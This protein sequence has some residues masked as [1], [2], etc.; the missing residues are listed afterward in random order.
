MP[1]TK[2]FDGDD[3]RDIASAAIWSQGH[4]LDTDLHE[5]NFQDLTRH[6][7][8]VLA[9][10]LELLAD[11]K[12]RTTS[13]SIA[14]TVGGA[15]TIIGTVAM[16]AFP[17]AGLLM[18]AGTATTVGTDITSFV[19]DRGD[20]QK[21]AEALKR[22]EDAELL[23][24]NTLEADVRRLQDLGVNATAIAASAAQLLTSLRGFNVATTHLNLTTM[25]QALSHLPVAWMIKD[26]TVADLEK[27]RDELQKQ[28]AD[29]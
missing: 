6:R 11:V 14:T 19:M 24:C 17:P 7:R 4:V 27:I 16:F 21:L 9:F 20:R 10:V 28:L 13:T 23:F 8:E 18:L 15:A 29:V 25:M 1:A 3:M 2:L 5:R 22:L 12:S 26:P